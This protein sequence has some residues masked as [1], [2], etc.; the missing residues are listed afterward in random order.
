MMAE[1]ATRI[2]DRLKA[3][4]LNTKE[5]AYKD[6][7]DKTI[8]LTR[9]AV[10]VTINQAEAQKVTLYCFKYRLT[11]TLTIVVQ[12]LKAAPAGEAIRKEKVY[13]LIEAI[14]DSLLLQKLGLDLENPL[15]PMG[16]RNV[17]PYDLAIAGYQLYTVNFWCS[18]NHKVSELIDGDYG[19]LAE[20]LAKYWIEPNDDPATDPDRAENLIVTGT[21]AGPQVPQS[22]PP[23][24]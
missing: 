7:I 12:Y 22:E 10:N 16:F 2:K 4:G 21:N 24:P 18:Y 17:T 14:T 11:V 8:N 9:P 5:V 23:A 3:S 19:E 13:D 1:L 6:L 20:I 15:M